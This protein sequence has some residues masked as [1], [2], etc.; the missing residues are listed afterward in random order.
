VLAIRHGGS[1]LRCCLAIPS[2]RGTRRSSRA[3]ALRVA[4]TFT[5]HVSVARRWSGHKFVSADRDA[6]HAGVSISPPL[7][8]IPNDAAMIGRHTT[9]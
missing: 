8:G 6:R 5:H 3:E 1:L 4:G 2:G 7:P 9:C